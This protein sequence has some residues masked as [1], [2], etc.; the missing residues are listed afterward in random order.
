MI[1]RAVKK[2]NGN[3]FKTVV[4]GVVREELVVVGAKIKVM[5]KELPEGLREL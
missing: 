4:R 1:K 3:V 2:S 5:L